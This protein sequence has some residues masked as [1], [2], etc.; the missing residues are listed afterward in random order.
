MAMF[1]SSER[2][3]EYVISQ[4]RCDCTQKPEM[5]DSPGLWG[6]TYISIVPFKR[7]AGGSV[8]EKVMG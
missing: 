7:E 6:W 1:K 2:E 4:S 3:Y 8:S 5:G